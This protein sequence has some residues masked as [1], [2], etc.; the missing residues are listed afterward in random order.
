MEHVENNL[1][2]V[3][4]CL[5][6]RCLAMDVVLLRAYASAEMCLPSRCLVIGLY[7]TVC[8]ISLRFCLTNV[9]YSEYSVRQM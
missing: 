4:A 2:I 8:Y 1:S 5:M 6:I 7:I 3:E 9:M